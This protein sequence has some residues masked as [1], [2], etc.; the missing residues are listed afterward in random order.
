MDIAW[1]G[2]GASGVWWFVFVF[3]T[4]VEDSAGTPVLATRNC[5]VDYCIAASIGVTDIRVQ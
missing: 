3:G 5:A 2:V 1:R 4:A